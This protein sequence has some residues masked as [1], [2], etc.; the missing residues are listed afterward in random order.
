MALSK[1]N[2]RLPRHHGS[3]A[4]APKHWTTPWVCKFCTGPDGTRQR[5]LADATKCRKCKLAK[6]SCYGGKVAS[7]EAP[8]TSSRMATKNKELQLLLKKM[9]EESEALKK[10][11]KLA[12]SQQQGGGA[13]GRNEKDRDGK[14]DEEATEES[15]KKL[16]EARKHFEDMQRTPKNVQVLIDNFDMYPTLG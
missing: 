12:K 1:A 11:L 10:Q 7:G 15:K 16:E 4:M 2:E 9:G 3:A 5:M 6:G 13:A 14:E 8:T